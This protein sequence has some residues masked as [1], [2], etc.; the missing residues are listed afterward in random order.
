[1]GTIHRGIF[2]R[3]VPPVI[4]RVVLR[5][6]LTPSVRFHSLSLALARNIT[7]SRGIRANTWR[8]RSNRKEQQ[9]TCGL[10]WSSWILHIASIRD[11][12]IHPRADRTSSSPSRTRSFKANRPTNTRRGFKWAPVS[13]ATPCTVVNPRSDTRL[14]RS[15]RYF[16]VYRG[17]NRFSWSRYQFTYFPS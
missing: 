1:M 17:M 11:R 9:V 13:V 2:A 5:S 8:S 15:I 16:S 10:D 12:C 3:D 6:R 7:Y 4:V 14:R